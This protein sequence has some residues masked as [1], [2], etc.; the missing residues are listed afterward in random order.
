MGEKE[1][2]NKKSKIEKEVQDIDVRISEFNAEIERVH[3]DMNML[4]ELR[5]EKIGGIK[6]VVELIEDCNKSK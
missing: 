6:T 1:L 2:L 3:N 4:Y 5:A